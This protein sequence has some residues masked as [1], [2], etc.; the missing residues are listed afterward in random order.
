MIPPKRIMIAAWGSR[1]DLQPVTALALALKNVGGG[2]YSFL[3][4]HQRYHESLDNLT[5]ADVYFGRG[6]SILRNRQRIKRNTLAERRLYYQR[7]AA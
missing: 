5:P 6:E 4:H 7:H 1:G 2:I 3:L